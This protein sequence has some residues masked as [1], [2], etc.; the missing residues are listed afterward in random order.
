M[1][2]PVHWLLEIQER[3]YLKRFTSFSFQ[4]PE[5]TCCPI[6]VGSSGCGSLDGPSVFA[7]LLRLVLGAIPIPHPLHRV[8]AT[9]H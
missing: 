3:Y 2:F 4:D 6:H 8:S 7:H 5:G 9:S 1:A